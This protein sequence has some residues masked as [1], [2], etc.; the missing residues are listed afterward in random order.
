MPKITIEHNPPQEKLAEL[1]VAQWPIWEK[2]ASSF[3]WTYD[4]QETCYILTGKVTVTSDDGSES[5]EIGVGDLVTFAAGLSC[6]WEIHEDIRKH[7][8]FE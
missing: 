4:A 6:D 5:V 7:Y 3:P 2:E 1:D 8:R